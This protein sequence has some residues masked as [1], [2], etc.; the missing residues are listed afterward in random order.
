M[1]KRFSPARAQE[2]LGPAKRAKLEPSGKENTQPTKSN[3]LTHPEL[4]RSL[5]DLEGV[6]GEFDTPHVLSSRPNNDQQPTVSRNSGSTGILSTVR[7]QETKVPRRLESICL[8]QT[9]SC[10]LRVCLNSRYSRQPPVNRSGTRKHCCSIK[11]SFLTSK[12]SQVSSVQDI[13]IGLKSNSVS[14]SF[15]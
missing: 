15:R 2:S 1:V 6:S 13:V 9:L 7:E 12:C 8:A 4:R 10:R 3:G 14:P 11:T 5:D